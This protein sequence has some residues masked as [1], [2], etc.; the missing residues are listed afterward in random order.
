MLYNDLVGYNQ[1]GVSYEGTLTLSI[2]GFSAILVAPSIGIYIGD[3]PDNSNATFLGLATV[4][5]IRSGLITLQTTQQQA[6]SIAES[7]IIYLNNAADVSVVNNTLEQGTSVRVSIVS[8][9]QF[10]EHNLA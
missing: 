2:P 5:L 4:S 1:S 8:R 6:Q 3:E 10:A 7:A 9:S